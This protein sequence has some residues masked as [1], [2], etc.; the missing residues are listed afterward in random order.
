MLMEHKK[1]QASL[2]VAV[3]EVPLKE[4]SRFGIMNTDD[5]NRIIEFEE[6]PENPKSNLASM[7]IYI[8]NWGRLRNILTTNYAKDSTMNDFG[9][10]VIP[11]YL[12]SGENVIAYRFD[13]YW[14]DVGTIDSLW[15]ANME[16]LN[17]EMALDIRDKDWRI[18][19]RN[20]I[21]PPH[22]IAETG[23]AKE[24]LIADGCYVAGEINHSILSDDVQVKEGAKITDSVIMS[25]ATIGKNVI[26]NRAIIG[27]NA[28]LGDGA[29]LDGT[30][31]IAVVGY[32]EVIG[33][34]IDED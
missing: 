27:E 17:P 2:S 22:F 16:F 4:A 25:G 19:S 15:E 1:K 9:K 18:Y 12:E 20:N 33:V 31:E 11:A 24:S 8:F 29:I 26:L 32:S 10:H 30:D 28:I 6:K 21:S 14:K 7:G 3:L 23:S 13:G 34:T 5:N